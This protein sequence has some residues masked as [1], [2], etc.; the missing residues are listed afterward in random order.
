[1]RTPRL[2]GL[3]VL[4]AAVIAVIGWDAGW[5]RR[6]TGDAFAARFGRLP[7][8]TVEQQYRRGMIWGTYR[9]ASEPPSRFVFV[10][11]YS[12]GDERQGLSIS[13]DPG[14]RAT[15]EGVCRSS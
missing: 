15:A 11:H 8:L 7:H 5:A 2:I 6:E 14:F 9:F 12:A 4:I 3:V 13:S 10:S 1:M